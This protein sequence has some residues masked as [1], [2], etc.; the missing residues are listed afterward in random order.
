MGDL[1]ILTTLRDDLL[2]KIREI[3]ASC[4]GIENENNAKRVQ[5]LNLERAQYQAQ[6]QQVAAQLAGLDGKL[7]SINAEILELSGTGIERILEAI[8]NQRWYF[9]KNKT[10][11]LLD[12]DTGLLWNNPTQI[13]FFRSDGASITLNDA[14]LHCENFDG[15]GYKNWNIVTR[16]EFEKISYLGTSYPYYTG[17]NRQ[18]GGTSGVIIDWN[19]WEDNR[20]I[21]YYWT[22]RDYGRTTD[23]GCYLIFSRDLVR[24]N[25]YEKNVAEGNPNYTEKERLQFTL[26]LFTQN[27]LLPIFDDKEITELYKKI[28]FEKP[29][30]LEQ[31]QEL[32]SQIEELQTVTLLSSD[33]DYTALL[34]KY[35]IK[36]ID[37]SVIK[38]YQAVQQ[39]CI[40][41]MEKL[42]Y[43]EEKK[44][45]VIRDFNLISLKLSKK[46]EDNPGL[47]QEENV[48]L[49]DRQRFFQKK[50]SLG[51]NSIKTKI[52]AVKK[53]ADELEYRIDEIDD[54][55]NSICELAELEQEK[56]ASFSFLAENTAKIIKNALLK[57]EYFEDNHSFVMNAINL[58][59]SWTEDYRVF[60]TTYK[61]DM[62]HDCEDDG[63]EE[64]TWSGWYQD[65]QQ[66]RYAIELKMQPVIERGLRGAMPTNSELE[67]SVPEQLIAVLEEY[68]N[69][70]DRFYQEER[71]GIYQ[72]FAFQAGGELQDKFET[73]SCLYK[74]V[75]IF[76]SSLQDIIFNCRNA[77][78][79]VWILNWANSL[80]DIQIDE[81]LEFIADNDLQK[82]SQII[83]DEFAA[84]KQKSYDIYLADV[85]AYGE[86][87]ARREKEYNSLVFKMRKDLLK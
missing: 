40:E 81:I 32:Q 72:K 47:T 61:E 50:F 75:V 13:P 38:Y 59:E 16:S 73:E 35:D 52:L 74:Y 60:K 15:D 58:W 62:K 55:V 17:S 20:D 1:S 82:I 43:Y 30:L 42:D 78:D 66:L 12:R 85:K 39:W 68:K 10:K 70:I 84:L 48:L 45:S 57:I 26:D 25:N 14:K 77:E 63:I 6:R 80:L 27:E 49:R 8:K 36:A 64:E 44:A 4:E 21:R 69:Q 5:E 7:S 54:G 76:Q 46:Y 65:W 11:I 23:H 22:D 53:Q 31:L 19:N 83:L 86:E 29:E 51:M 33:F 24:E 28:Y 9:F 37:D 67:T 3:E 34:A 56:R 71:K 2:V 18:I 87:K 79:R 41:L